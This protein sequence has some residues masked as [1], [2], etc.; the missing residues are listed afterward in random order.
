MCTCA[1]SYH[2]SCSYVGLSWD[3][4]KSIVVDESLS[5]FKP[6]F[7]FGKYFNYYME[8]QQNEKSTQV[9]IRK[10]WKGCLAGAVTVGE[11]GVKI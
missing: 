3:L 8:S 2:I 7:C 5:V 4:K 1:H 10:L 11:V 6:M 9:Y